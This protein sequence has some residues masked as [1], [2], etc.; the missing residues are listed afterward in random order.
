MGYFKEIYIISA[1]PFLQLTVL[2]R[3]SYLK[4]MKQRIGVFYR[5]NSRRIPPIFCYI[6]MCPAWAFEFYQMVVRSELGA[7]LLVIRH[8]QISVVNYILAAQIQTER[9]GKC[10]CTRVTAKSLSAF[11]G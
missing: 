11:M 9:Y 7:R 10:Q 1:F 4:T 6:D 2:A 8:Y 5:L 3:L